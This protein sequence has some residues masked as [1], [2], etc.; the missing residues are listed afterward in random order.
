[1]WVAL[2]LTQTPQRHPP[3]WFATILLHNPMQHV[4]AM[5]YIPTLRE[6]ELLLG[7][8]GVRERDSFT[9]RDATAV[10]APVSCRGTKCVI[11]VL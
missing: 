4:H 7:T 10:Q 11:P 2:T 1:M 9:A 5:A 6:K 8:T 3:A